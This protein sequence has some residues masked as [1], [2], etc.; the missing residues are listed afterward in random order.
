MSSPGI[1]GII[2][3]M[4]SETFPK[5]IVVT[6]QEIDVGELSTKEK[7]FVIELTRDAALRYEG[8]GKARAVFGIAGPS[9]AGK[10]VLATLMREVALAQEFPFRVET[11]SIDA[12]HFPNEY[13][14][15]EVRDGVNLK[16]VKG[17]YD[18]YDTQ[19]L[20]SELAHFRSG[21]AM[22]F[23]R[24]SRKIHDPVPG[25]LNISEPKV[26][27][28]LEGL[29]LLYDHAGWKSVHDELDY[30]YFLD[31]DLERLRKHTVLRHVRGGREEKDAERF[32][33]KCDMENYRLVMRTKKCADQFLS[34]PHQKTDASA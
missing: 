12:F 25:A 4:D 27:L 24:Y 17:R 21:G 2:E 23:P 6:E 34:W 9:G 26:L 10:S 11:L 29:W 33:E 15:G 13:L 5:K 20:G 28:L 8:F 3:S 14:A 16:A 31:D 19:L 30:A 32:Y 7:E 18:T 1:R 22:R